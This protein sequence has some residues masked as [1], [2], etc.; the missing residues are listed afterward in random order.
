M[1]RMRKDSIGDSDYE[2]SSDSDSSEED[3]ED[4]IPFEHV[5]AVQVSSQLP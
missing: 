5:N 3:S 4:E 1:N 2:L